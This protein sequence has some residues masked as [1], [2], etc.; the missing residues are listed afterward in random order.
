M[1]PTTTSAV[2]GPR[3]VS[4]RQWCASSSQAAPSTEQPKRMK[5]MTP[6]S[7]AQRRR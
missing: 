7:P 2:S 3:E 5:G 6:N 1:P 4:I